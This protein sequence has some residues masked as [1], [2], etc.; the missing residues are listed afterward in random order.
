MASPINGHEV[1]QILRDGEGQ[2]SLEAW[3]VAVHGVAK[4]QTG[5]SN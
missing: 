4:S 3:H 1:E 5:L 2:G